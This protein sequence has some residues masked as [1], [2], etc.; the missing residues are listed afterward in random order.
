M[1][2]HGINLPDPPITADGIGQQF[3]AGRDAPKFRAAQQACERAVPPAR[4]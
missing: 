4:R 3:P 2:Q 1:R